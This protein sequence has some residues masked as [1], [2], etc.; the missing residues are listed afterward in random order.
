[1]NP[2]QVAALRSEFGHKQLVCRIAY[3]AVLVIA[4]A[5]L[6]A[7]IILIFVYFSSIGVLMS[8]LEAH[9]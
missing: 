9:N 7:C 3:I 8:Y 1:M 5:F 2:L 6:A 4:M